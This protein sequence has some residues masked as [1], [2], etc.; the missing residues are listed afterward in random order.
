MAELQLVR[1]RTCRAAKTPAC[2]SPRVPLGRG[3]HSALLCSLRFCQSAAD[4][5]YEEF[6]LRDPYSLQHWFTYLEFKG[7]KSLADRWIIYERAVRVLPGSYKLWHRYIT[8]RVVRTTTMTDTHNERQSTG[9]SGEHQPSCQRAHCGRAVSC[10]FDCRACRCERCCSCVTLWLLALPLFASLLWF[11]VLC[12]PR[13][14]AVPCFAQAQTRTLPLSSPVFDDVNNLFERC[15]VHM[16][17]MPVI[18]REYLAFLTPQHKL[19]RIRRTYD[20]A[21]A[22]L[23]VTQHEKFV[24]PAY[25]AWAVG[26]GVS[27]TGVRIYRRYLKIDP[28]AIEDFI[29]FLKKSGRLEEA[30]VQL[31]KLVNDENFVSQ[32]GKSKHDLWSELLH[33]LVR[34]PTK[35]AKSKLINVDAIIRS[36]IA[37]F[38]HEV[39]RLWTNLA[40]YYIRLGQF[41]KARDIYE[42]SI[43]SVQTVRDFSTVFDAYAKFEESVTNAKM[44]EVEE[45]AEAAGQGEEKTAEEEAIEAEYKAKYE[46]DEMLLSWYASAGLVT[47][48]AN[49]DLLDLEIDLNMQRLDHL[50]SRRPLLLSSVILRQNPHHVSEWQN[51]ISLFPDDPLKQIEVYTEAVSTI[52]PF[53]ANNGRL[54]RLWVSFARFYESHDDLPNARVIFAK[55][56]QVNFKNV[57]QLITIWLEWIEMELRHGQ[58]DTAL[59]TIKKALTVPA[60]LNRQNLGW[61]SKADQDAGE[62]RL[63]CQ[64][65]VY[66]ST[67]LWSLHADLEENFGTLQSTQAVYEQMFF[68]KIITPQIILSYASLMHEHKFYEETFRIYEKGIALFSYPHVYPIWMVYLHQFM[69]R[70]APTTKGGPSPK[71]ERIRDL[72]EQ[73]I[74]TLPAGAVETKKIYLLYAKFEED[75]GLARRAMQIYSRACENAPPADRYELYIVYIARCAY[76]F[77]VARTR[78]IYEASIKQLPDAHVKSMCLKYSALEKRLGEVDRARAIYQ[79]GAQFCDPRTEQ[80]YW[81][82]W[83][84]FEVAH[85]NQETFKEMLRV[86]RTVMANFASVRENTHAGRQTGSARTTWMPLRVLRAHC[87]SLSISLF[88]SFPMLLLLSDVYPSSIQHR[89]SDSGQQFAASLEGSRSQGARGEGGGEGAG[90]RG[91]CGGRSQDRR[92]QATPR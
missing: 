79:Y 43:T 32:R 23:A 1:P 90:G 89:V 42:E 22:S 21:L 85:G 71:R 47:A 34:N 88:V 9:R 31:T 28:L 69:A 20:R 10:G 50:L 53:L 40:D 3:A 41:E 13:C 45:A 17:K 49:P 48:A 64:Q 91:G 30:A 18:W 37:R 35:M 25:L 26:C 7:E 76:R 77:G 82:T 57:D 16:H 11:C 63:T 58:Y 62:A 6:I 36:G 15:L 66:K 65:R 46:D 54:E 75:H 80:A 86:K 19:T 27:E 8:E 67:K 87:C 33:L 83:S 61:T 74:K 60:G 55:A 2:H 44:K 84:E 38:A 78:E 68:L 92:S 39:G 4:L 81:S 24:W 72:F 5:T 51:R 52:D 29:R 56:A 14:C 70:Y 59:Q 73:A 12:S